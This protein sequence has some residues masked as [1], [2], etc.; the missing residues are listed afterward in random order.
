MYA[1]STPAIAPDAPTI[2][3]CDDG[4]V[5]ICDIAAASPHSR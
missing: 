2:G 1:P 5:R 3:I 4:D